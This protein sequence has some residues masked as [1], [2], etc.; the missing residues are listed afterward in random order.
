M[1]TSLGALG[2]AWN[3]SAYNSADY[4]RKARFHN[5]ARCRLRKLAQLIGLP[6]GTYDVRSNKAG[7][8]VSGEV[9]LHGED[10]YVQASV[11]CMGGAGIL[12][13]SCNGRRDYTGGA[14]YFLA[15]WDALDPRNPAR[16][17][18]SPVGCL[19]ALAAY[20]RGVI[21]NKRRAA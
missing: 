3:G 9:T 4:E 13:R 14:N 21:A 5:T 10:I 17:M 2:R 19:E 7:M 15:G 8:A 16:A 18:S 6:P 11:S 12:V 20:C 1:S